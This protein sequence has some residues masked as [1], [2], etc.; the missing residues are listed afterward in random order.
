MGRVRNARASRITP[1][2][3]A[4][5]Q[6]LAREWDA[7]HPRDEAPSPLNRPPRRALN[8][9]SARDRMGVYV[10]IGGGQRSE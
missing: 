7:A 1:D 5:A 6:R 8:P 10:R 2:Q 3:I 4:E 9:L